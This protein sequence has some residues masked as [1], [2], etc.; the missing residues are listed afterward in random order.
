MPT[1]IK[2]EKEK[3]YMKNKNKMRK[4]TLTDLPKTLN[5][6]LEIKLDF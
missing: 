2:N 1:T 6:G 3:I 4:K 5:Q